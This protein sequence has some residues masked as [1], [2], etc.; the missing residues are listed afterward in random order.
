MTV[1]AFVK[2]TVALCSFS[3]QFCWRLSHTVLDAS[4]KFKDRN[5]KTKTRCI[6]LRPQVQNQD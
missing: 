4:P 5:N 6:R 2:F 1:S 3:V